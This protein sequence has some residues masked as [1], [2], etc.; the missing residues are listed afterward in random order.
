VEDKKDAAGTFYR[1]NRVYDPATGRFTQEDPIGLAGGLNL[2]GFAGGDPV[3]FSDPFGLCKDANGNDLPPEQCRQM[4]VGAQD[5]AIEQ[6]QPTATTTYCNQATH[7]VAEAMN[8]PLG[9]LSDANGNAVLANTMAK[10]MAATGSGYKEVSAEVAQELADQGEFVIVTGP[11]HVATVR[12]N[13]VAGE[14]PTGRGPVIANVGRTNGVLRLNYV[15]RAGDRPEV[16]YF[17]P[18]Y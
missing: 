10:R 8:V 2:Y 13:N 7:S 4:L 3:N 11:G 15:F 1:R 9:P 6:Y 12:P 17:T 18:D 5:A 14:N 16:R